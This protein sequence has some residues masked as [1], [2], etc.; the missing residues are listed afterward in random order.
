M[1]N[2]RGSLWSHM[3]PLIELF[4]EGSIGNA[5]SLK[6][7]SDESFLYSDSTILSIQA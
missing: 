1:I 2:D 7:E 4:M 3:T 6:P 5:I